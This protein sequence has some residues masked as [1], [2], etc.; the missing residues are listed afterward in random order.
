MIG[1][2][3]PDTLADATRWQLR[4]VTRLGDDVRLTLEP[5]P[6]SG[7]PGAGRA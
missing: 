5:P 2:P 6:A 3:G 7:I 4:D 1:F